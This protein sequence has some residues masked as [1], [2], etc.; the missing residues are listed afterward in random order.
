MG[1]HEPVRT[2]RLRL[3][4]GSLCQ[5]AGSYRA[6]LVPLSPSRSSGTFLA[7]LWVSGTSPCSGRRASGWEIEGGKGLEVRRFELFPVSRHPSSDLPRP[8]RCAA[9]ASHL[10]APGGCCSRGC[11]LPGRLCAEF[12]GSLPPLPQRCSL[13]PGA[14]QAAPLCPSGRCA[15][16]GLACVAAAAAG[17]RAR[18]AGASAVSHQYLER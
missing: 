17:E 13:S 14:R 18:G 7:D 8:A 2:E 15:L 6:E 3:Q 1:S 12:S 10:G 16:V 9:A 5:Q 4:A 11:R